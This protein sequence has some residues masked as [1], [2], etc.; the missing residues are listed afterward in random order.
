MNLAARDIR[1]L[2]VQ[3]GGQRA[4]DAAF[5]LSAK[6][7][8]NEVMPR[9]NRVHD[10]RN[11][12]VVITDDAGEERLPG[13]EAG[14]QVLAHLVFHAAVLPSCFGKHIA[15]AKFPQSLGKGTR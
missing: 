2:L 11:H 5:C 4:Q 13:F 15:L 14:D 10:L 3:H 6:S 9:K 1:H 8:Q 12:R 7:Q